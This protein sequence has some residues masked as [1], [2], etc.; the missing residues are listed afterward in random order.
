M[1]DNEEE[2]CYCV[3]QRAAVCC[4]LL[5]C[6]FLCVCSSV[7]LCV[8]VFC[9]VLL[10]VAVPFVPKHADVLLCVLAHF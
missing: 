8:A 7:L 5:Q 2:V 10:C 6:D 1:Y 4:S 3:L 9:C